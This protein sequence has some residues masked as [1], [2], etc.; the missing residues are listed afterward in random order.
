MFHLF[1]SD[2]IRK[3]IF[4]DDSLKLYE[5]KP[6]LQDMGR[7]NAKIDKFRFTYNKVGFEVIVLI[8][9]SPFELLFGV[10]GYNYSFSLTLQVGYELQGLPDDVFYKLCDILNLKPGRESLTSYKFLKY[11]AQRIPTQYSNV[12]VQPHEIAK[13]KQRDVDEANKIYFCGWKH[14]EGSERNAKNFDKT[15]KLLGDEAYEFCKKNNISSCWTDID[16]KRKDYYSPQ[17]FLKKCNN[18]KE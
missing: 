12:K 8:E 2:I 17:T 4:G 16:L 15:R 11:V 9:R 6:L 14:F 18:K 13:Y 1:L 3:I 5:I 7:N 10:I